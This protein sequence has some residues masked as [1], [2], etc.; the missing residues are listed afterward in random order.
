MKYAPYSYS[1]LDSYAFCP[2]KFKL[3]YIS[4]VKVPSEN[5]A[6]EKG[7]YIHKLIE[8]FLNDSPLNSD[9]EFKLASK[10]QI[11]EFKKIADS[12]IASEYYT[13]LKK[14]CMASDVFEVERGFSLTH[15]FLPS[16]YEDENKL[17]HGFI[18]LYAVRGTCAMV[19]DHKT[20]K[21]K[22][23]QTFEQT[24][25]YAMWIMKKYPQVQTVKCIYSY[26][27][28]DHRNVK[29][30]TRDELQF[31]EKVFRPKIETSIETIENDTK[32]EK[33]V[34]KLCNWCDFKGTHCPLT[35]D[36][37]LRII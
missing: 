14:L 12:V 5:I 27:E 31:F 36:E 7:S 17:L 16:D 37:I 30:F 4:K 25:L 23:R 3:N 29:V 6:L 28:H 24:M 33:N 20:G 1:K 15:E 10:K 32:F 35:D 19:L 26:V 18:D 8:D 13:T 11:K 2:N 9:F 22:D 34:T 21:K